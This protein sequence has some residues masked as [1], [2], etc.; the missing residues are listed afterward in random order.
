MRIETIDLQNWKGITGEYE[1]GKRHLFVGP[2]GSGKS[3]MIQAIQFA[4]LGSTDIGN[5]TEDSAMLVGP[6]GGGVGLRLDDGMAWR[7]GIN[8]HP[9][10][11][12]NESL[13]E[14]A[15]YEGATLADAKARLTQSVGNFAPMFA[16]SSFLDLSDDKRRS[17]VLQLCAESS[18]ADADQHDLLLRITMAYF[19]ETL[20]DKVV[21][22]YCDAK[23]SCSPAALTAEQRAATVEHFAEKRMKKQNADT[24]HACVGLLSREVHLQDDIATAVRGVI[25]KCRSWANASKKQHNDSIAALR[26][27]EGDMAA[28]ETPAGNQEEVKGQLDATN[29]ELTD[30]NGRIERVQG[31]RDAQSG[32]VETRERAEQAR[33]SSEAELA[34]AT[35]PDDDPQPNPDEL[36]AQADDME[37]AIPK[38]DRD[39]GSRARAAAAEA[40]YNAAREKRHSLEA[41]AGR[42]T[43]RVTLTVSDHERVVLA[44]MND[45]W[46]KAR[47]LWITVDEGWSDCPEEFTDL[48]TLIDAHCGLQ[49][50]VKSLQAKKE[51]LAALELRKAALTTQ[52]IIEKADKEAYEAAKADYETEQTA[53][54]EHHKHGTETHER[55]NGLRLRASEI[56]GAAKAKRARTAR[57]RTAIACN[58]TEIATIQ[59]QLDNDQSDADAEMASLTTR[60]SV[61]E[62]QHYEQGTL[63]TALNCA[64][65]LHEQLTRLRDRTAQQQIEHDIWKGLGKA[66]RTV[67]EILMVDLVKPLLD[68]MNRFLA[69]AAPGHQA[70]A[71]LE[72]PAG[73]AVFDLGWISDS[74][75]RVG[76]KAL[77]GGERATFGAALAYA[78]VSVAQVPMRLLLLEAAEIDDDHLLP[79]LDAIAEVSDEIDNVIVATCHVGPID[80]IAGW[81]V[82]EMAAQTA[83]A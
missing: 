52:C 40:A 33:R 8:R 9:N 72:N 69:T 44:A 78:L 20:G 26:R 80:D 39:E 71:D 58:R 55:A 15:G 29:Q 12:K 17:F 14:I 67:R 53:W 48:G 56:R 7:R 74:V 21:A 32:L 47:K 62:V 45:P 13:L 43:S 4:V 19:A 82:T 5:R 30:N 59:Q 73:R 38:Y 34:E 65:I 27:M 1:I 25:E 61:L 77:S 35:K 49:D 83:I 2:N 41:G 68:R 16:L 22:E 42:L 63:Y 24:L 66:A 6:T 76:I 60:Q 51:A 70:Y 23:H 31:R 18:H 50:A 28:L 10:T 37:A 3:A 79:L 54:A 57:I 64:K 11:G 81:T 75:D 36:E 46:A